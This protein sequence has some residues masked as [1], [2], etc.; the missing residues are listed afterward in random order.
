MQELIKI[1]RDAICEEFEKDKIIQRDELLNRYKILNDYKSSFVTLTINGELRGCIGSI[2]P[3]RI[4]LDDIVENAK[5]S[6]FKDPRF[7]PLTKDE[8]KKIKIEI[9]LLTV[10]TELKYSSIDDLKSKIR[11]DIDGV[12]IKHGYHQATFLPQVWEELNSFEL[13]F[14][15]LCQKAGMSKDCLSLHPEIYIYNVEKIEE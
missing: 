6:A 7:Y 12:I 4:L 15:H 9:S 10:P 14:G 13:F 11:V 5:S 1:A 2:I 3:H 8:L